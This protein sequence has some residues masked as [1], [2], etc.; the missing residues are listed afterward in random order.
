MAS[1][2]KLPSGR[3]RGVYSSGKKETNTSGRRSPGRA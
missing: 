3:Y 2:E 1:A